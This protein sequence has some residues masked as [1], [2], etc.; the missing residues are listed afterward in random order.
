MNLAM[1]LA[2]NAPPPGG[3]EAALAAILGFFCFFAFIVLL[4]IGSLVFW[5]WTIIDVAKNPTLTDNERLTW[6]LVVAFLQFIG[7]VVYLIAGRQ[8]TKYNK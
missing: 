1:L 4:A 8:G 7:A 6:I 2:Q 5:I 3:E